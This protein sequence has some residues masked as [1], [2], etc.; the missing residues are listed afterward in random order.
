MA[1]VVAANVD[2]D[3]DDMATTVPAVVPEDVLSL[4][5]PTE[6]F[7]CPEDHS[8]NIQFQTFQIRNDQTT[9]FEV[10][11]SME[12]YYT[13]MT[14]PDGLRKVHYE[15]SEDVLRLPRVSTRLQFRVGDAELKDFRMIERH[16]FRG[17]LIKSYDF[18]FGYCMPH[19]TNVW[20]ADYDVPPLENDVILAMIANPFESQ[21]DSFYFVA[22]HL[23][24]HNKAFYKYLPRHLTPA[25]SSRS[26]TRLYDDESFA[27]IPAI[28]SPSSSS[29]SSSSRVVGGGGGGHH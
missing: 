27:A 17:R 18:H 10:K 8:Q 20:D 13:K 9:L 28:R 2:D 21:S 11:A 12:D 22:G 26:D 14:D 15:L 7:L 23:V 6:G 16:Y 19:S 5:A 4:S 25:S 24:L 3:D 29:S 1:S